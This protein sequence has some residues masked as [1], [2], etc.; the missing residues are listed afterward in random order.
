MRLSSSNNAWNANWNENNSN[1][2][3]NNNNKSNSNSNNCVVNIYSKDM[4]TLQDVFEAYFECRKRKRKTINAIEFELDYA[5]NCYQLWQDIL[6]KEY[7]IGQSITF[8]I[9]K[10]KPREIFAA[11]FRDRVVH[12]LLMRRL[13]PL[14]EVEFINNTFNCRK[15]KGVLYG[16]NVLQNCIK[17]CSNNFT[18]NCYIAKF[19]LS[20]FFTSIDKTILLQKTKT[21]VL[22]KYRGDDIDTILYLT[23][24]IIMH[25][26]QNNCIR[27]TA[28]SSWKLI[29]ASKSLFSVGNNLGLPIG[30][31]T[32]QIFANFYLNEFDHLM[33]NKFKYYGRYV[34]DF[35]VVVENKLDILLFISQMKDFLLEK[36]HVKLHPKKIYI[37]DYGKGCDFIGS[38]V[39]GRIIYVG[40]RTIR[41]CNHSILG[42]NHV[43]K[44]NLLQRARSFMSSLNSFYGFIKPRAAY[45]ISQ[46]L[47]RTIDDK[48]WDCL[49]YAN[50]MF[51]IKE[52]LDSRKQIIKHLKTNCHGKNNRLNE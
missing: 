47:L 52:S 40:R 10:P 39:K 42:F 44:R 25:C 51:H 31:L 48:W 2:N 34:D 41:N 9:L 43:S 18:K 5:N 33:V 38:T 35:F 24:K 50:Q 19:D 17:E 30:N 26:P 4:I 27:K 36:I 7:E 6:N 3:L 49:T 46:N 20:G 14:F 28:L 8:V 37:Q 45:R 11:N 12:H 13:E 15:N 21:F 16:V 29:P 22:E 23:E 1:W 32:S